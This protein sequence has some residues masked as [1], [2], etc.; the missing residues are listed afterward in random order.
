MQVFRISKCKHNKDLSGFGAADKGGRW[1]SKGI[2]ILYSSLTPSLAMLETVAHLAVIPNENYCLAVIDIP[3]DKI[4]ELN[5]SDL[6]SDWCDFPASDS[7]K[8]IGDEFVVEG[9]FLGL[10]IPSAVLKEESNLLINPSHPDFKK[11][12][13]ISSNMI[14]IDVRLVDKTI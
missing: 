11:A 5:E 8:K 9:K 10:K 6:P 3:D 1:N 2:F 13:L 12:K 14:S 4:L 7:L